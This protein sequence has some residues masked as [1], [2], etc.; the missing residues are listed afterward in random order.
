MSL[1]YDK[2]KSNVIDQG[3]CTHCGSC[4]GLS[5]GKLKFIDNGN[6]PI[7][8][9]SENKVELDSLIYDSCPGKGLN[10]P[11]LVKSTFNDEVKDWRTGYYKNFF[12]G[13]SLDK[14]IRKNGASGGILTNILIYLLENKLID[15]AIT[16]K[17]G[18]PKPWLAEPIIAQ[19][20]EEVFQCAQSVYAP[21]P[22]N[23]ILTKI[24]DFKGN[25]AFVG[26]PDQ[27]S[28]IRFLQ[29]KGV[30]SVSKIKYVIGPYVG[31]NMYLD[32][33]KSFIK[34][35]GYKNIKDIL[36]LKYRDGEW[37]GYLTIKMSDGKILKA[38]KFYYN[39]LIPFYITKGSLLSI[40]FCNELTDISVGDAWHP[41]YEKQGKGFSVIV[42]RSNKGINL[43]EQMEK[44]KSIFLEKID[45]E[46]AVKMHAHMID[47]KKRG[48]FIRFRLRKLFG[49]KTP[50]FGY[51][52]LDI[53]SKR[54]LIELFISFL[55]FV[56]G[57]KLFR[58]I[59]TYIPI[60]II[61][62]LFNFLR[63]EWKNLSK[64]SKRKG[65]DQYS[66]SIKK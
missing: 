33:V 23:S 44:E 54:I 26:L 66:I 17:N 25:L 28:S 65:L 8:I 61:G 30:E 13:Y 34:S 63:L 56:C 32:S 43:L 18:S 16:L 27:V 46:A 45:K 35:H 7:P 52:P 24:K 20:K 31:T 38:E 2:L 60:N 22:I 21:V 36:S 55:F 6:G 42:G 47:F 14:Q 19:T 1:I 11:S 37:P 40:D 4:V 3:L 39:Y 50:D 57:T 48:S 59:I 51:E 10:Y 41:K 64:K 29:K 12:I 15:G 58:H 53:S 49:K 9:Y 5:D 62:P